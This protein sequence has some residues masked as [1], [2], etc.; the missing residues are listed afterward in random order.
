MRFYNEQRPF[1][2]GVD[3]HART[4]YLCILD[5]EGNVV[6]HKNIKTRP[7]AL[8]RAVRAVPRGAGDRL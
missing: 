2:C 3:L 5:R 7:A 8:L 6:L 1:Y 4:M